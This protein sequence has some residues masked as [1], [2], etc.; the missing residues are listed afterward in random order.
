MKKKAVCRAQSAYD[1]MEFQ[2]GGQ[3]IFFNLKVL[4]GLDSEE[5]VGLRKQDI[6]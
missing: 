2:D 6:M 3:V 1:L 5:I 4:D